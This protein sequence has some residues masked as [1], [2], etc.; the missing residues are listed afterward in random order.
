M[1][2]LTSTNVKSFYES[3]AVSKKLNYIYIYI[4]IGMD[5]NSDWLCFQSS[6]R[7][8]KQTYR[9][10]KRRSVRESR[11]VLEDEEEGGHEQ[12]EGGEEWQV[13]VVSGVEWEE[14]E[15]EEATFIHLEWGWEIEGEGECMSRGLH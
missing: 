13:E 10:L 9:S 5:C 1:T 12:M 4:Y 3:P 8:L 7:K 6:Q 15:A 11:A 2:L 14:D